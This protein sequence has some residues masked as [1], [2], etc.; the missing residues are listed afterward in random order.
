MTAE[1][2][3]VPSSG[4]EDGALVT[5]DAATY[6]EDLLTGAVAPVEAAETPS[7]A[8]LVE[9]VGS[10]LR[11]TGDIRLG[12]FRRLSDVLNNHEGLLEVLDATVLYRNGNATRVKTPSI[13]VSL[14]E[15]TLIGQVEDLAQSDAPGD[16]RIPKE[17]HSLILVTPGHTLTGDCYIAV[18]AELSV[19]I[20]STDPAFIPMRDVRT[21][22]LADRRVIARYAFA[23]V[24][25]RQIVA[26]TPMLPGMLAKGRTL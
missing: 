11:L 19:F 22:S 21:R 1:P 25:R 6:L 9:L 16:V 20:E 13:W 3:P 7:S 24:N 12:R 23:A 14:S 17:P 18:G 10:H 15:V 26:A 2:D 5:G 4:T 8:V